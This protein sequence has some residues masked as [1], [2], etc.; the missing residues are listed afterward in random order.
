MTY[1]RPAYRG[2]RCGAYPLHDQLSSHPAARV[3]LH[4]LPEAFG[5]GAAP[6][7][8]PSRAPRSRS[9][10]YMVVKVGTLDG[11]SGMKITV[12]IW[13]KSGRSWDC[14]DP[15]TQQHPGQPDVPAP[16]N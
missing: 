2:C 6:P 4:E 9:F 16:T 10:K 14:I 1:A 12:N 7:T 13:T 5:A 11:S 8:L 15:A 3:P